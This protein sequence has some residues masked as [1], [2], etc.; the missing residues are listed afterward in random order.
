MNLFSEDSRLEPLLRLLDAVESPHVDYYSDEVQDIIHR[1]RKLHDDHGVSLPRKQ[2]K[3]VPFTPKADD[4]F[5]RLGDKV[6]E[7]LGHPSKSFFVDGDMSVQ[8][9][10]GE[11]DFDNWGR[12]V[13]FR[14]S[15]TLIVRT[16]EG[17]CKVVKWAA[18]EGRKVRVAGF[19]HSWT[20]VSFITPC[21]CPPL[22][23]RT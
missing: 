6:E 14:A 4:F 12:T 1:L 5:D 13:G 19:R 8:E 7:V 21:V 3:V 10:I 22:T 9:V 17:V 11:E 20:Y 15:H 16:I 23:E 18:S 2:Y